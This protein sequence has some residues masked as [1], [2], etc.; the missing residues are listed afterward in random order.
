MDRT[1]ASERFARNTLL[2]PEFDVCA[3]AASMDAGALIGLAACDASDAKFFAF[4]GEG[5]VMLGS[6]PNPCVTSDEDVRTGRLPTNQTKALALKECSDW[7]GAYLAWAT[8]RRSG[9]VRRAIHPHPLRPG[10]RPLVGPVHLN[11]AET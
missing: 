7:R 11:R 5:T 9:V 10:R 2:M 4:A 6:A 3:E 8:E 1:S